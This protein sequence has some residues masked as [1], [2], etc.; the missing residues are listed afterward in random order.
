MCFVASS[1]HPLLLPALLPFPISLLCH[2][3]FP[4]LFSNG[5][6]DVD[7]ITPCLKAANCT[8]PFPP[9][10]PPLFTN[11]PSASSPRLFCQENE[12]QQQED[13]AFGSP[14]CCRLVALSSS[15]SFSHH[16]ERRRLRNCRCFFFI[17]LH[18]PLSPA[19]PSALVHPLNYLYDSFSHYYNCHYYYC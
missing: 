18:G 3:F 14:R 5:L 1:G 4:P 15:L 7:V 19:S 11:S 17:D 16:V 8:L 9:C 13:V 6:L 2:L 10:A 12:G